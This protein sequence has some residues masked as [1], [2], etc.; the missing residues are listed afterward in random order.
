MSA[1]SK[2][3]HYEVKIITMDMLCE[4]YVRKKGIFVS[5]ISDINQCLLAKADVLYR[6]SLLY[7]Y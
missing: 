2:I 3:I 6:L 7:S 4:E 1:H 5:T